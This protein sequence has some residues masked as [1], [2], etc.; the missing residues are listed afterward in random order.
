MNTN[1]RKSA[2]SGLIICT[3]GIGLLLAATGRA[4]TKSP[5]VV[6]IYADDLGYGDLSSYGGSIPTPNIDR[7]GQ[8]GIRFTDFYV[9][10]PVCTPSRYS[11][12][13]GSYPQRSVHGL[14][15]A[16]MPADTNY[17]DP[18]ETTLAQYLKTKGY[19]TALLGKWHLGSRNAGDLPTRHGF[20]V[21]SGFKP[22]CIDYFT[23]V[24]GEMGPNWFVNGKPTAETGYSTELITQHAA[25]FIDRVK[26]GAAPFFLYLPYNAPHFGKTDP[27]DVR[28]STLSLKQDTY[29]G[30]RIMN[31]LQAPPA[32]IK[33]FAHVSDPYRRVYAA[34]VASLDDQVGI[35]LAKL[36]KE[37]LL[38]NT[39]I[40]FISDN[41]GYSKTYFGHADN[42]GLRGEK[43][44]LWEGGIRVPALVRWKGHIRA[45]QTVGVPV[46][47]TDLVPTLGSIIGFGNQLP[48]ARMDG[49]DISDVLFR[50]KTVSRSLFWQY[51]NQSAL[52]RDDWKLVNGSELYN[53]RSDRNET[54]N[55]A[56]THPDQV[57]KLRREYESVESRLKARPSPR[58]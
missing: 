11:L 10:A 20:D 55:L 52:R 18:S 1:K 28:D 50:G 57:E 16:L 32:Y 13:T 42:G 47:T 4:P 53:L 2:V 31:S 36:E 19:A 25:D 3:I 9:S 41:G 38:D 21:F 44:T 35:L 23:H 49:I 48:A 6:I 39:M 24:Y 43:A 8:E 12:L 54:T 33:K 30:Y 29:E 45:G 37:G 7:I 46:C 15:T 14:L 34:M 51:G 40:W 58:R 56:S 5:N 22:G 17:L 26:G 27:G